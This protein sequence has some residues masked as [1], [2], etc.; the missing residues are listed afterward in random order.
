MASVLVLGERLGM[1]PPSNPSPKERKRLLDVTFR[2]LVASTP[3]PP[4]SASNA[5]DI[6]VKQMDFPRIQI[7]DC[8]E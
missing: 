8:F 2:A 7:M 5:G 6:F 1:D 4:P 3:P